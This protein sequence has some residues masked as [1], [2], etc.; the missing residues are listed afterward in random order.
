MAHV[1]HMTELARWQAAGERGEVAA[2]SLDSDG[3][4][5]ASPDV[6]TLLA[7]ANAFYRETPATQPLVALAVD[8]E[9]VDAEVRWEA[10][11]PA[12]PP[13]AAPDVRFPHI[14]GPVPHAAVTGVLHL[15]RDPSG[16][17]TGAEERPLTAER[18]DLLPHPEGGWFRQ[19]WRT[20]AEF[21][22]DGY[23][24]LRAAA[25]GIHF[26]LRPGE[27]SRWHRVRSDEMWVFNRGGPLQ[28]D[29]GGAGAAPGAPATTVL[30]ADLAAGESVQFLVPAG[31]W[32][33]ARPAS[34]VEVLVSCFVAPGF[35]FADFEAV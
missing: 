21:Q 7:V 20:A 8:T 14:Y 18:L 32:Q 13:G 19:T 10:A 11:D 29:L 27:E 31:T 34:D 2:D 35:D 15:R 17:F 22:P 28:I 12:P 9:S 3:F 25:T 1:W 4:V 24:G 16:A 6:E 23:P 33:A 26:L 30:G 5:H